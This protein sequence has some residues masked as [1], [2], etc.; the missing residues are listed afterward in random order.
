[1]I[2][3][4]SMVD[5][6]KAAGNLSDAQLIHAQIKSLVHSAVFLD[7]QSF[8]EAKTEAVWEAKL[9]A[10]ERRISEHDAEKAALQ[11]EVV[12]KDEEILRLT[13]AIK[14]REE[15]VKSLQEDL[16]NTTRV[17]RLHQEELILRSQEIE[18]LKNLLTQK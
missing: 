11:D 6:E 7:D 14:E 12:H 10:L 1:M 15:I 8:Q 4:R 2:D 3:A 13:A 16:D 5:F 9:Q 17:F 18:Q